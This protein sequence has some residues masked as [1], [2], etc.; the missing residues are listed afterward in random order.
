MAENCIEVAHSWKAD[1]WDWPLQHHDGVVKLTNT[2]DKFEVT[3]DAAFFTPNEIEVQPLSRSSLFLQMC[4]AKRITKF[5]HV[6]Y[7]S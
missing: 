1:Q 3:L 6:V 7:E 4:A 5:M 2:N